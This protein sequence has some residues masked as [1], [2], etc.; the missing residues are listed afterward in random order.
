LHGISER[1]RCH[2][3]IFPKFHLTY[4]PGEW[5]DCIV[6]TIEYNTK[7]TGYPVLTVLEVGFAH[8]VAHNDLNV[9]WSGALASAFPTSSRMR[10]D[11]AGLWAMLWMVRAWMSSFRIRFH[12]CKLLHHCHHWNSKSDLWLNESLGFAVS[13]LW[14]HRLWPKW[15][16]TL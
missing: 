12:C 15:G 3:R 4:Q 10:L 14:H 1:K 9:Y 5:F 11:A 8:E 7:L 2:K 6:A 16:R 13:A